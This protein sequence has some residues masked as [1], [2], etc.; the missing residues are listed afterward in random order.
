VP[1]F[2]RIELPRLLKN[3]DVVVSASL[4]EG[5]SLALVEA[6]ACGLAPV[7]TAVGAAPELLGEGAGLLIA[8]G[9]VDGL[10][11]ALRRLDADRELLFR[12]RAAAWRT[13]QRYSWEAA[14]ARSVE[15]Y[16]HALATRHA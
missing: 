14:G 7:A 16:E 9:S 11:A 5:F 8:P 6:M 1:R 2:D 10:V 15:L 12:T 4:A 3:Q 13:A